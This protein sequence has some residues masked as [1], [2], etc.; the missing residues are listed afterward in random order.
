M[1]SWMQEKGYYPLKDFSVGYDMYF[2][3]DLCI[4][5]MIYIL[6]L[7]HFHFIQ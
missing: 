4:D 3:P 5:S 6:Q 2:V 7:D 1:E